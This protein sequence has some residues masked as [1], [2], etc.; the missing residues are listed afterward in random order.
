MEK[1]KNDIII[2]T[3]RKI[4]SLP[5]KDI[6]YEYDF[7]KMEK[8]DEEVMAPFNDVP[9]LI[10]FYVNSKSG[11]SIPIYW[12]DC[13]FPKATKEIFDF[14]NNEHYITKEVMVYIIEEY[15]KI[16]APFNLE[17]YYEWYYAYTN[18]DCLFGLDD[19]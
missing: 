19:I 7:L 2:N 4:I 9:T 5:D 16:Y 1:T 15:A 10:S 3:R 11:V 14:I 13:I 6:K 8:E 17:E 12:I 18:I